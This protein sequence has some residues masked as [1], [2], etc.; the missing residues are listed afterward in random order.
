MPSP[1][2]AILSLTLTLFRGE[3]RA[4]VITYRLSFLLL[5]TNYHSFNALKQHNFII[6]TVL[7]V[8]AQNGSHWAAVKVSAELL[9][10]LKALGDNL[11]SC[12][13]YF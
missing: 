10:S 12:V 6:L 8:R 2:T 7:E 5:R 4:G 11:V 13:F 3:G 9:F 1:S